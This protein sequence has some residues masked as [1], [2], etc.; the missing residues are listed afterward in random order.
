MASQ[1]EHDR[2]GRSYSEGDLK[3]PFLREE[4]FAEETEDA[5]QAHLGTLETE[6]PFLSA[7]QAFEESQTYAI[8][9][10]TFEEET[11]EPEYE[12]QTVPDNLPAD[13]FVVDN[14]GKKYFDTF[15]QLGDLF[16]QKATV[17]TPPNFESLMDHMLASNQKSFV[18]DAHGNPSGLSMHLAS[19]TK[20]SATKQSLF[21]LRGI[22]FIRTLVRLA[23]E[24]TT[25]WERT[26]GTDLDRWR[27]IVETLHSKTWQKMV[28]PTWPTETPQVSDVNAAR[29]IVQSRLSALVDAL[30]PG[31]IAGRQ[32]RVDRLIQKMLQLQARGTRE[33]QFRACNIGK[34]T[35][36]LYEFRKFFG[37]DH[38]CAP[39]VRSGMG[40][41]VPRIDR[42][43]VDLLAKRRLTQL[44]DL[45]GGRFAIMIDISGAKFT[46]ACAA[47][48]Q[49]AVGEWVASHFMANSRYRKG[50]LP[51]HFLQTQPLVFALDNGYAAHIQC[52][53]SFWEGAVRAKEL[54]EEEAHQDAESEPDK[55]L[56]GE[57]YTQLEQEEPLES[58]SREAS[59]EIETEDEADLE[60]AWANALEQDAVAQDQETETLG[61]DQPFAEVWTGESTGYGRGEGPLDSAL[62]ERQVGGG[63]SAVDPF[64]RNAYVLGLEMSNQELSTC[65]G[66]VETDPDL[67]PMCGAVADLTGNPE[68]PAFYANNP[69]DMVYVA[70]LAKVYPMYVVFELRRRVQEQAKDMIKLGLS[71]ATAG[72]E[73][74]VFAALEKAWKPKLKAAFPAFPE[75]MPKFSEIFVLS[76]TGDVKFAENDPPLTDADLDFR[77]PYPTPGHPPISPE[78]KMP[79]G[80]FRDWMRLML[81]WSNNEAASKVIRALSYPYINGVL[82]AAGF[83][84][85]SSRV[86]LWLSGDYLGNDW[87]KGDGAAQPLSPRWARLQRR[88]VTNFGGTAFQVARLMTLLA[89]GR[90]VD[91]DSSREMISIMTGVAGIGSYIRGG[92]AGAAPPR[93]FTSIASKIGC[94]DEVPPPACGFP[95][96][97]AIVRIDRGGDPARTIRYVVV[98]LGGRPNIARADLRKLVVRFHDCVVARHP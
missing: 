75:D 29:S 18:I 45:P 56:A 74:Q 38:L 65:A 82:G 5:W 89:Q 8:A 55:S 91:K 7:F 27:Q 92:L 48:T 68:L 67:S 44:Y 77:P 32:E 66:A 30:F 17:L 24:S 22:E 70:S 15:P 62:F 72:W 39:D 96:D 21:I 60:Q 36:S 88:K 9:P 59:D 50:I 51:I 54:E 40:L 19:G 33:I 84:N 10:E 57:Q 90:L 98:A 97:C 87:L 13:A 83:F 42:G 95:H 16:V 81:R 49:A 64:P 85:R 2:D 63:A 37:A 6:S 43:A 71:T 93:A 3:S 31:G 53:S 47:D 25:I 41:V 34:D 78:F 80:K 61:P 28:G 52:R 86:G 46:A 14:D 26:S 1:T 73:R 11:A 69:A 4:P 58:D 76:P 23:K 35:V 20:I 94:G 79:P 12:Y